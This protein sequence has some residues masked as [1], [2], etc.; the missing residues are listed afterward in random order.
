MIRV[1]RHLRVRDLV[2]LRQR[3]ILNLLL[4]V[5]AF[6]CDPVTPLSMLLGIPGVHVRSLVPVAVQSHDAA[7][8]LNTDVEAAFS[9]TVL[10]RCEFVLHNF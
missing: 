1:L 5:L 8:G 3:C 2:L 10:A 6:N 4:L 7:S 9:L